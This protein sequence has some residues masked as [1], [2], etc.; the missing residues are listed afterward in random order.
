[1]SGLLIIDFADAA[2]KYSGYD[3]TEIRREIQRKS[4]WY[5]EKHGK[6]E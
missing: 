6:D 3:V 5:D 4:D 2:E 1:M